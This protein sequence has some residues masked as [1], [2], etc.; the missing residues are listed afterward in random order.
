[1]SRVDDWNDG[2]IEGYAAA[3]QDAIDAV[4]KFVSSPDDEGD[5]ATDNS[6]I[7][8]ILVAVDSTCHHTKYEGCEPCVHD[9][10]A[11]VM[12]VLRGEPQ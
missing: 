2:W 6:F 9:D 12:R 3:L 7:Q 1:M 5:I 4:H 8:L 10:A 11:T